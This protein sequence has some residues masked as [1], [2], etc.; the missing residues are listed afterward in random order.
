L[1]KSQ[2]YLLTQP[3]TGNCWLSTYAEALRFQDDDHYVCGAQETVTY[4]LVDCPRL[5]ELRRELRKK[6]G[7]AFNSVSSLLGGSKEAK[8]GKLDSM[9]RAKVVDAVLKIAEAS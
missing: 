9:C 1:P 4:V 7:D 3:R 6:A 5:K 2:A 8:R